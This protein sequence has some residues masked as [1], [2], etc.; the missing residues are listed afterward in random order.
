MSEEKMSEEKKIFEEEKIF[1]EKKVVDP[2]I[3]G[4]Y[5]SMAKTNIEKITKE[6]M[7]DLSEDSDDSDDYDVESG[8]EDSE[9]WPRRPSHTIFEKSTI[10]QS[11]IDAMK[12]RYFRDMSIVRVGGDSTAPAPEENEVVV[13]RSFLKAGLRFPLSRFLV[14]VLKIFQIFLHQLTPEAIIRMGLFVWDV[15]SQGLEPSV[16]CFCSMHEL[17]YET[18]A[19][20]KEQYHNNFGCYGFITLSNASY[21]VPTF[22][23]RWPGSWMEKWFYVKNNLNEMENIK[24]TI[25][26]PIW[27]RFGLRR[28]TVA[29]DN[30]AEACQKAFSNACAFIGTR[31]LIQEHIAYRVWPLVDNWEM[32]KETVAGSSEGG[33]IRLKY[34]FRYRDWFDE[35]N[36]DWLKC[37][38]ATSDELLGA[39]TRAEDDALS[40]AF[41]SRGKKRL[42][43]V[44]DAIDFIYPDYYY[45]LRWQGKKRKTATSAISAVPKG[46]KIKVLMHRPRYIETAVVPEFGEGTSS[47]AEAKQAAPT[48]WSAEGS[49][50]VPK[51]PIVGSAEAKDG[52]AKE[53]ELE[54]T[55]VL[56]KSPPVE[57]ELWKVTKA[58][59]TTPKRRRMARVLDVVMETT[60]ALTPAPAKKVAEAATAQAEAEAGPLVPTE[61]KP[62][63]IEDKAEQESPNAGMAAERDVTE[64]AESLA[65]KAPSEDIDYIIRHALGK[66]LSEEEILEAKHYAWE[67]KYPK[68][69]L[70]FN[71]TDEDD[72]LYCL[73]DNKEISI[74]REM[75]KSMGF[76][77]LEAGLSA[78]SKD[79]LA[80][81]LAYNSMK[82]QKL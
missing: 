53:P 26:R 39:Y 31:D 24:G 18:K 68:G 10:K 73:P 30:D 66:R 80:D 15:R 75:A 62:A 50:V 6:I 32:P 28:P 77:K 52:V 70:V 37:I 56:P 46:K 8:D 41:A 55:I 81:N 5:E 22:Q 16:K 63:A 74:Y 61:T 17:L 57:A 4:F 3:A 12:G 47:A 64:K 82:V 67:L 42:N 65:P 71:G 60:K 19:T 13:N 49:T 38:E 40:S 21:P 34:T 25:Q 23:K 79:D 54:K 51:V 2:F 78:M 14:E 29:I 48:V 69:A 72:F 59:A 35:P 27:S 11:H 45:P 9:D 44:F 43:R 20:G 1:K 58:P 7:A 76:L 33:L 36:D